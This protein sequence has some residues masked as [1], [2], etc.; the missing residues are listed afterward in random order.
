[1]IHDTLIYILDVAIGYSVL[2]VTSQ[3]PDDNSVL[4]HFFVEPKSAINPDGVQVNR[5]NYDYTVSLILLISNVKV[6][7]LII[8]FLCQGHDLN[9]PLLI[10]LGRNIYYFLI[11]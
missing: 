6:I 9:K 11:L 7:V 8:L 10:N 2:K 1:M 3:D 4:R 5:I